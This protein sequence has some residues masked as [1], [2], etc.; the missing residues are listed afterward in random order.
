MTMA[1]KHLPEDSGPSNQGD[2]GQFK[3]KASAE[4]NLSCEELTTT[5]TMT[6]AH[7][8]ELPR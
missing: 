2:D 8:H 5:T 3:A 4:E 7:Q 6:F 1:A